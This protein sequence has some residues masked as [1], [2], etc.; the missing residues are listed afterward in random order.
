MIEAELARES[1]R[2]GDA[3]KLEDESSPNEDGG[4]VSSTN[5]TEGTE[6]MPLAAKDKQEEFKFTIDADDDDDE[7]GENA[8]ES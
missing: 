4:A 3:L 1:E 7:E 2:I 5:E 6:L 8:A